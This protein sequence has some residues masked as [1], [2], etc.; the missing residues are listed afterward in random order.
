[1]PR[2]E[3]RS[4]PSVS[5]NP[6]SSTLLGKIDAT[7]HNRG[8]MGAVLQPGTRHADQSS[9]GQWTLFNTTDLV[10]IVLSTLVGWT[11]FADHL[12]GLEKNPAGQRRCCRLSTDTRHNGKRRVVSVLALCMGGF[13]H[14]L[15]IAV[16]ACLEWNDCVTGLCLTGRC[17]C[18]S[19]Y[20]V[21]S[22]MARVVSL[23]ANG[24]W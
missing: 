19:C 12:V 20:A 11:G 8:S 7:E 22:A 15:C 6:C 23:S 4:S 17:R 21:M 9:A 24:R 10:H 13:G 2:N 3:R 16:D 14:C 1:M 18:G 5:C